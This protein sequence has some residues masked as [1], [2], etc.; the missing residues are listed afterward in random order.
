MLWLE[1][2]IEVPQE[3][4]G[5]SIRLFL[6]RINVASELYID[7]E[8]IGRQILGLSTPHIYVLTDILTPGRH[9][10]AI[11]LDNRNLIHADTM[12]SG[13]SVDTQGYW[14]GIVGRMEL[15]WETRYPIKNVQIYTTEQ[16]IS[17]RSVLMSDILS[18]LDRGEGEI[19]LQVTT[20]DGEELAEK[21]EKR[22]LYQTRQVEYFS[23]DIPNPVYWDEFTPALYNLYMEYRYKGNVSKKNITFGLRNICVKEK[24]F[25]LNDRLISLRGT[26]DCA[27]FP[28]TGYP[29]TDKTDWMKKMQTVKEYGLNH[30]RFH[31]WCPPEAAFAA[32][33]EVGIYLQVEMPLWLNKDVC[34]LEAGD[35]SIHRIFFTEEARRISDT[36]GNHPSFLFFSNGNENMGDMELLEDILTMTKA[37]DN[38]R[39]YTISSNFDHSML[40]G[41]DY[42][43]AYEAGGRYVRMQHLQEEAAKSTTLHFREA[44]ENI[45]VP[46]VSF[47]IGQYCSFPDVDVIEKY[48]GNMLPVNFDV[49]RRKMMEKGVYHRLEE[50]LKASGDLVVKL[51]KEEIE[52]ALRTCGFGG[53]Q[54]LSLNDYTG[55]DTAIVGILD[56]F[57]ESK[58]FVTPEEFRQFCS[59]VVPLFLGKR[60]FNNTE[61]LTGEVRLYDFGKERV[62]NPVFEVIVYA[63][64]EVF[65]KRIATED[66]NRIEISLEKITTATELRLEVLLGEYKNTYRI[67]VGIEAE[68]KKE[69]SLSICKTIEEMEEAIAEGKNTLVDGSVFKDTL[70]CGFVPVF[71]SPAF[72]PSTVPCGG[73]I[74]AEHPVFRYFPTDK[75]VDY[76]WKELLDAARLVD[77]SKFTE[78]V[79][80]LVEMVPNF[81]DMT[82]ASPL[83]ELQRGKSKL[84]ICGFDLER[85]DA[86]TKQLRYS[87]AKYMQSEEFC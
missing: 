40:P 59:P 62:E 49:I 81:M 46:I 80:P 42:L 3:T 17:L 45:T 83:F 33:D 16:G 2:E 27:I 53:F 38:R 68:Q 64:D 24:Q 44:V 26:T 36:Y 4:E 79:H 32:A 51:Y 13:Y 50:Y 30:V 31:A 12:A 70:D 71:W 56:A 39:L 20:P 74:E 22:T 37:Y 77:I 7:G 6:E 35:D 8:K 28:L 47:E 23:Y 14:L 75:Y 15:Q 69:V 76:Q 57:W 11:R 82:P 48:T 85:G 60:I 43:C 54:L 72:F 41:E 5:K 58:G 66:D 34:D 10:I 25:C 21:Y 63:G 61:C 67:F 1:R 87:I 29:A 78:E 55:Q 52:C 73:M 84:L 19:V 86:M 65:A 18:P 9:T